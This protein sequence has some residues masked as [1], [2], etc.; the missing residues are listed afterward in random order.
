MDSQSLAALEQA[1]EPYRQAGFVVTAQSEGAITLTYPPE[2]FN[3]GL[4]ILLLLLFW[5]AAVFYLISF[6]NRRNRSVCFRITSQGYIE[7][8][9]YTLDLAEKERKRERWVWVFVISI[10]LFLALGAIMILMTPQTR[11]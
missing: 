7:E 10:F 1:I 9:G 4:F 2:K 6:N 3:Y 8:S 11:L 5:P